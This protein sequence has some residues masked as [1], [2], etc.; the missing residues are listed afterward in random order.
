MLMIN[1]KKVPTGKIMASGIGSGIIEVEELPTENIDVN[2]IYKLVDRFTTIML[3]QGGNF[4]LAYL[5]EG[6]NTVYSHTYVKTRPTENI[7]VSTKDGKTLHFYYVEDENEILVYGDFENDDGVN[8]WFAYV[9]YGLGSTKY[10]CQGTIINLKE[11]TEVGYYAWGSIKYYQYVNGAWEWLVP[12]S[13][14]SGTQTITENGTYDVAGYEYAA[15][16]VPTYTTVSS[17]DDLP[18]DAEDGSIVIVR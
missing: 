4:M 17:A 18:E 7:L 13:A 1:G 9:P 8:E 2:A 5:F 15:V 10:Q 3:N 12:R 14:I 11:A 16:N 6:G